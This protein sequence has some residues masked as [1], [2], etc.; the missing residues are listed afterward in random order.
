LNPRS[1][2][3]PTNPRE[4]ASR[5]FVRAASATYPIDIGVGIARRIGALIDA[6]GAPKRRFIVSNP[7]VWR[8]HGEDLATL[9]AEEPILLPDGE[10]FKNLATVG[11]IYD[12][13]IRS[14]ADRATTIIAVGGG[15][16]GDVAGFAAATFL[17]GVPVVQVPTTLLAQVDSAIGGKVGVNHAAGKNLIGAYHQPAGVIVDPEFLAS[18]P[19]REFRAGLYEV[20]KYGVIASRP[21]F[22]QLQKGMAQLF[23]RDPAV[24]LPIIADCCRIKGSVVEQD[25][26]ES[27]PR[28]ALNF[29]HT[30][31]H[32]L[33]AATKYR[34]FRHGEAVGYG[35]LAAA[36]LAVARGAMAESDRDALGQLIA[37]MG[38]MPSVSDLSATQ[39]VEAVG[40]DKKVIAGHLHFVLPTGIGGTRTVTDVTV[41]ELVSAARGIGLAA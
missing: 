23:A 36:N 27:G 8:F 13:L 7:T 41:E 20:V 1:P 21:L 5:L 26:R 33:E 14:G 25:E 32:A 6:I 16:V 39:V 3:D 38:P 29:G 4:S 19:R 17:R 28:R 30:L 22:E 12:A 24:L 2:A 18:L 9:T 34:R 10:R 40:R 37:Q 11:R 31:G 35:M 15:V